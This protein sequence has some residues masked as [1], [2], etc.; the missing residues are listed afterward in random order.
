MNPKISIL[1]A[2]FNRSHTLVR[3]YK[4]IRRQKNKNFEWIIVD[5]GS[6]DRTREIVKKWISESDN[7]ITYYPQNNS[8]KH[9][10]INTGLMH[11]RGSYTF[12]VDSDDYLCDD[13][14]EKIIALLSQ[15]D[16]KKEFAGIAGLKIHKDGSIIGTTF[17]GDYVDC[18]SL[19]RNKYKI[20]G[21]KAE[22]FKT[23]ILKKHPFPVIEGEKF[24]PEAYIW[25][26]IAA[27]GYKIRW[28]NEP[29]MV[30]EYLEDGL[31]KN[32]KTIS[33]KNING[34]LLYIKDLIKYEKNPIRKIAHYSSYCGLS[35]I[36][37]E[38]KITCDSL[39][40][41]SAQYYLYLFIHKIRGIINA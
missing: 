33:K 2:T 6:T 16:G 17:E 22:V 18:T 24:M 30:C 14:I 5:D 23:D 7:A 40:I 35:S 9:V 1:T 32:R 21:D 29:F 20:I 25:N 11:A 28:F 3:L 8:G 36:K 34:Q 41:N 13:A 26:K 4:S 31:T 27:D 19:E 39:H 10:A 12:I 15:I 38:R 37:Y